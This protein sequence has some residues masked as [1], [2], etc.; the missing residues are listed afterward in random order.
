MRGGSG[1]EQAELLR[2]DDWL[3]PSRPASLVKSPEK[4]IHHW[5]DSGQ[6]VSALGL[7]LVLDSSSHTQVTLVTWLREATSA[8]QRVQVGGNVLEQQWQQYCSRSLNCRSLEARS[9][10][11]DCPTLSPSSGT[12]L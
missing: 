8:S 2:L 4:L 1:N 6:M 10:S 7:L 3:S 12:S 11:P 5:A 9:L